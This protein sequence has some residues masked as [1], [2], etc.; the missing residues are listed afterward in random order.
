MYKI[1]VVDDDSDNLKVFEILFK[2]IEKRYNIKYELYKV[3]WKKEDKIENLLKM[4]PDIIF[5]DIK[6]PGISGIE[7]KR[8]LETWGY[9]KPI[10]AQTASATE[11]ETSEYE[12]IF[13]DGVL[14]KPIAENKVVE[15]LKKY[16]IL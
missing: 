9:L 10:V 4:N 2:T 11:K 1:L 3:E 13:E 12:K 16:G 14:I 6:L 5:L 7:I 15:F 8:Q